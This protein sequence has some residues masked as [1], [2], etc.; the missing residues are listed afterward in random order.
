VVNEV[1]DLPGWIQAL[2]PIDEGRL[3]GLQDDRVR[4]RETLLS[5]DDQLEAVW[6][7]VIARGEQDRTVVILVS[8]NGFQFGEHRW[9]GKQ[10]PFEPSI[11]IPFVV[12]S[13]WRPGGVEQALVST[14]DVA[15]T[16]AALVGVSPPPTTDGVALS[17]LL[18]GTH[19]PFRRP[20]VPI[21]WGGGEDVPAWTGLRTAS[22]TYVRWVG[23]PTELYLLEEDP[24]QLHPVRPGQVRRFERELARTL[25]PTG[26]G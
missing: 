13:P 5:V 15:P 10:T 20:G 2:P 7:A 18:R 24:G 17:A 6:Q 3:A 21:T 9:V 11:R 23:G 1:A 16:I 12:R 26:A 8:D 22:A 25:G 14:T 19:A 4:A